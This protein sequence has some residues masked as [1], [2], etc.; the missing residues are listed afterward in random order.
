MMTEQ[1]NRDNEILCPCTGTRRRQ[2]REYFLQG[3]DITAISRMTG[4]QTG[5]G[6]CEWDIADYLATLAKESDSATPQ[7]E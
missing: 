1:D 3:L 7:P 2:I 5:C 4:V 6:G